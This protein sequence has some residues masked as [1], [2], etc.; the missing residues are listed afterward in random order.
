V[1][2]TWIRP[3]DTSLLSG[4][5]LLDLGTGDGQTLEELAPDGFT[6]GVDRHRGLLRP[7]AVNA[8]ADALPF[9]DHTFAVVLAADLFHHLDRLALM[10]TL[11]EVR[12]VLRPDGRVVAWWFKKT[13]DRLPDAPRYPRTLIDFAMYAFGFHVVEIDLVAEVENSPTVGALLWPRG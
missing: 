12:R 11:D 8:S 5:P 1:A 6:V 7:G 4:R 10:R 3:A 2:W 9:L 13:P